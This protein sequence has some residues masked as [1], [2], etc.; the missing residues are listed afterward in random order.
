MPSENMVGAQVLPCDHTSVGILV[1][2]GPDLLLIQRKR[3]PFGM[4]PPAGHVDDHTTFEEAASAELCE[5]VG[6]RSIKLRLVIEG[7]RENH[8][9][10]PNGTWHFWKIY[11]TATEG[12]LTPSPSE[13]VRA[14]WVSPSELEMLAD[15]TELYLSKAI[16]ESDWETQPGLEPIWLGWL[17]EL[18]IL[19]GKN[20]E[21][22][23]E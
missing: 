20:Y 1:Y 2:R 6:L 11:Q 22:A 17:L 19:R 12:R 15:R 14:I 9:R 13:T 18:G 10:R 3:P 21:H 7:R 5:E 4:A 8:C 23:G 16:A